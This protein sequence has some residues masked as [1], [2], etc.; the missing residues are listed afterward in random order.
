MTSR[1]PATSDP[2]AALRAL[3]YNRVPK[4]KS[5]V[6]GRIQPLKRVLDSAPGL[7][8]LSAQAHDHRK[9]LQAIL[10]L[11][12]ASLRPLVQSGGF[13]EGLWCLLVPH[14][15]AAAKLRQTLPALA[16]HLRS[17]G[18]PVNAIRVKVQAMR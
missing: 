9:R 13:E 14:S 1:N 15:A 8:E 18:W 2:L 3:G 16:A 17:K 7:A 11:L 6:R 4:A 12:P 10:P 5:I